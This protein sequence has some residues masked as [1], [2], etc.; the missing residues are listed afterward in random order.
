MGAH[1]QE[2]KSLGA[3]PLNITY[4]NAP[5]ASLRVTSVI[6][7]GKKDAVLIDA[8]FTLPDAEKVAKVIKASGKQLKAVY[9]SYGD[10]DFYFGLEAIK[11]Y[12]PQVTVYA[13]APTIAR[14]QQT[15]QNKLD[16]WGPQLKNASP[17]NVIL[18]RLLKD[19]VIMLEGQRLEII[20]PG[21][22]RSF[23]WI[24]AIRAVVGGGNISGDNLHLWMADDASAAKRQ[25]WMVA[26]GRI[27][28]LSPKYVIPAHFAPGA[29]LDMRSV[30]HT[31]QYIRTYAELLGTHTTSASLVEALKAKYPHLID[32]GGLE[33]GAKVNT[34][35]MKW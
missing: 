30:E 19:S 17:H 16:V 26:L 27:T 2:M 6:V 21:K 28:A 35:E 20:D 13:T 22:E 1:A 14:I 7:S 9:I 10:P 4:Y 3:S 32:G 11:R 31:R 18:P 23:V 15:A 5:A 24:P 33:L 29:H 8:Q 25:E 34:G 12:F